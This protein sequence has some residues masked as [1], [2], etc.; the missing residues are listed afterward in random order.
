MIRC[1]PLLG[2]F[3]EIRVEDPL[4]PLKALDEAFLA[5]EQVQSLMDFHNPDSELS[6]INAKS[7]IETIRIHPWTAEVLG[8]AKEVYL[9]S[10][11]VFNCG[12]GHH[13]MEADLLPRHFNLN[14]YSFGGIEDLQFIEPSTVR[15]SLPLCL[16]LGGI[17]KGYAVDKAVE[18][19]IAN[20]I[21]TGSVNAG[22]DIRVFGDHSQDIHI[23]NPSKPHELLQI[24]S[25]T[26]G[27]IATS[28][29]Y[30]ANRNISSKSFMVHPISQEHIEF[31][32]S[33][34]VIASRCVYADALTKVVS[35]SGNSRHPCLSYFFAQAIRISNTQYL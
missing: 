35:I 1:K 11:G 28:S 7:Y 17:A 33:Y 24:G 15:S 19:L 8:V 3:V 10:Q 31:S 34:S 23:R 20:G 21:Q 2:T 16:D 13:L 9:Q 32:G 22:G 6:Q 4:P 26:E 27:A 5:V 14:D 18:T 25:M 12:V 30:F 29:L